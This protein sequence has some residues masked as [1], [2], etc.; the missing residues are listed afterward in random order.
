MNGIAFERRREMADVPS[1]GGAP[2]REARSDS[3][4]SPRH[5]PAGDCRRSH[6][7]DGRAPVRPVV[8]LRADRSRPGRG[9]QRPDRARGRQPRCP[10]AGA[11]SRIRPTLRT[12]PEQ[13]LPAHGVGGSARCRRRHLP[14]P[15]R[16]RPVA[17]GARTA[18][19]LHPVDLAGD[20][21]RTSCWWV[22]RRQSAL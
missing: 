19:D 4:P 3:D 12:V 9:A 20:R 16:L 10:G 2:A 8:Q 15:G 13:R 18:A 17:R 14:R 7:A 21:R 5:R 6:P 1:P 22:G 11:L